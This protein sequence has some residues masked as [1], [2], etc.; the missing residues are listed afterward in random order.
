ME[1]EQAGMDG[2]F[3]FFVKLVT[4][5]TLGGAY[6]HLIPLGYLGV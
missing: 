1:D 4:M 3:K 6:V 2:E 5:P